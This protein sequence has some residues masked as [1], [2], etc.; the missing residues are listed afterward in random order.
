MSNRY[1]DCV[2]FY[3][4]RFLACFLRSFAMIREILL[5]ILFLVCSV[6]ILYT[7]ITNIQLAP[8]GWGF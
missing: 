2:A 7:V 6:F 3:V 5:W 8:A 4:I 1:L